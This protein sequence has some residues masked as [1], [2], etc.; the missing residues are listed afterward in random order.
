MV[1]VSSHCSLH[2]GLSRASSALIQSLTAQMHGD[3]LLHRRDW[4]AAMKQTGII[5]VLKEIII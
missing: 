2:F 5:L 4:R 1:N 3:Y